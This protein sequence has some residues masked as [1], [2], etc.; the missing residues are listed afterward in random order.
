MK[1]ISVVIAWRNRPELR[2]TLAANARYFE[3][4]R[5]EVIIVN[6]GGDP[7]DVAALVADQPITDLRVVTLT[8]ASFNRSLANNIGAVWSC[9]DV[10]F[11]LDADIVLQ[12]DVIAQARRLIDRQACFVKVRT[13]CESKP[14]VD[15]LRVLAAV[16]RPI[17]TMIDMRILT[18]RDGRKARLCFFRDAAGGR[19]GSG[20]LL[21]RR[22]HVEA[23]GGFN[24]GLTGWGFDDI[25]FHLRLQ[26]EGKLALRA[27]GRV[28]HLTH[29]DELRDFKN[30][31][32][33]RNLEQN[34]L[35][36]FANY[37]KGNF[38]GTLEADARTWRERTV[39]TQLPTGTG[40]ALRVQP[41][42]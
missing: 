16:P 8:G 23:I 39:M 22:T 13:V 42:L 28:L 38:L 12:S 3:R 37:E 35:A 24:S 11:F 5:A 33:A 21:L 7:D 34:K 26:F 17:E 14:E 25:D 2:E 6:C 4:H 30:Q 10:L 31:S 29:G 19:C 40:S 18:L 15:Q 20:L 36:C 27:I 41:A 32:G 1:A 9:G